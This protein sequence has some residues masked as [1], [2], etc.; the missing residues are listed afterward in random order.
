[1]AGMHFDDNKI[2]KDPYV[3]Y[4]DNDYELTNTNLAGDIVLRC[5]QVLKGLN[6]VQRFFTKL[7]LQG[8]VFSESV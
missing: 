2:D 3:K 7:C 1:M 6:F 8:K 4:T 5:R